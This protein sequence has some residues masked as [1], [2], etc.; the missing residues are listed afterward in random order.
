MRFQKRQFKRIWCLFFRLDLTQAG[1]REAVVSVPLGI[2]VKSARVTVLFTRHPAGLTSVS[3]DVTGY[4]RRVLHSGW[5]SG[6]DKVFD[7][8]ICRK[9]AEKN[10]LTLEIYGDN[11]F[12]YRETTPDLDMPNEVVKGFGFAADGF[13]V[14][15]TGISAG[16]AAEEGKYLGMAKAAIGDMIK[17]FWEKGPS[18]GHK[19]DLVRLRVRQAARQTRHDVSARS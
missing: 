15:V 6:G 1:R 19:D 12:V 11:T 9:S 4:K 8:A 7:V 3:V 13:P 10:A 14:N 16:P 17:N 2:S 18:A 5:I